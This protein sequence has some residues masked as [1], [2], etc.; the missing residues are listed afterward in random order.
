MAYYKLAIQAGLLLVNGK[1]ASEDTVIC[2]G[3]VIEHIRHLHEPPIISTPIK[4][5][6]K[7]DDFI[8]IDKPGS[9]PIHPSGRY[10]KHTLTWMLA[11]EFGITQPRAVNRLDRLTSGIMIIPTN[12]ESASRTGQEFKFG[13]VRK[14][15]VARCIGKFP[16]HEVLVDEPIKTIDKQL[17]L[18]MIHPEGRPSQ[19]LFNLLSY[20]PKSNTS[21][22][23]CQPLTGRSH[24]IR[25]HLFHLGHPIPNDPIYNPGLRDIL[26]ETGTQSTFKASYYEVP[27]SSCTHAQGLSAPPNFSNSERSLSGEPAL[28]RIM[29]P[30]YIRNDKSSITE[31]IHSHVLDNG[32]SCDAPICEGNGNDL[33]RWIREAKKFLQAQ[34]MASVS[35]RNELLR[36]PHLISSSARETQLGQGQGNVGGEDSGSEPPSTY[37]SD[38]FCSECF[39]PLYAEADVSRSYIYLHALRYTT[40]RWS[41]ATQ[42]PF[43]AREGWHATEADPWADHDYMVVRRDRILRR[44]SESMQRD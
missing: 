43:W 36:E 25:V 20:D 18:N 23:H 2:Q 7:S 29:T 19:T 44:M 4:I 34:G 30:P 39:A 16:D 8:V 32:H 31:V 17:S 9:I 14:E 41:F 26:Y 35:L 15:Y 6:H 27:L 40:T 38:E 24:Q 37:S 10:F 3:D 21:V 33:D 22:V 13:A 28:R 12:A 11:N 5:L 42:L 1:K